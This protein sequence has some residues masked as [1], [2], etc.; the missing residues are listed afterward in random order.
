MATLPPPIYTQKIANAGTGLFASEVIPPGVE[1]LRVDRPLV[2]V[3]DT[4]HLKDTC[5]E[6]SLWLPENGDGRD[7][8]SKRLK[9]CQ[10]CKITKYCSKVGLFLL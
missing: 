9:A 4:P 10:G 3:L 1:I 2:S 7:A 5:S 8:Q 6:C